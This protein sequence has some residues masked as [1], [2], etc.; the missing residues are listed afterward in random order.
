MQIPIA[1]LQ[2]P[3]QSLLFLFDLYLKKKKIIPTTLNI[4]IHKN[5]ELLLN[6]VQLSAITA[7]R[8]SDFQPT[9]VFV[10]T[11]SCFIFQQL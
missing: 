8:D 7:L 1:A 3:S 6:S 5:S 9:W 10:K 4:V 11:G 2:T